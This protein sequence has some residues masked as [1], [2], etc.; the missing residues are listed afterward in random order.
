MDP[1]PG[2]GTWCR[3]TRIRHGGKGLQV[4]TSPAAFVET[5]RFRFVFGGFQKQEPDGTRWTEP[6]GRNPPD[7]TRWTVPAGF[8]L[9]FPVDPA[10]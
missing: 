10:C 4:P 7:G 1:F 2:R 6:A 8:V 9:Q 5:H 3:F